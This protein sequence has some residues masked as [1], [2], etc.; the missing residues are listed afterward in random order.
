MGHDHLEKERNKLQI[1]VFK[2]V[3]QAANPR[4]LQTKALNRDPEKIFFNKD[5][6]E[7]YI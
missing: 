3:W 4:F 5:A 7:K 2:G 1:L 6:L